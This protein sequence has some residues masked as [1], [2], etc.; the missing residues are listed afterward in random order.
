[1]ILSLPELNISVDKD[2]SVNMSLVSQETP[3]RTI[4]A[5]MMILYNWLAARFCRDNR[6]P[7]IFRGQKEP[8][9]KL[10]LEDTGYVYYVFRQRRKL[11]PLILDVEPR[12]HAGLGLDAY[13]NV[14]SP[15][16]RFFDLVSQRQM[17]N[18][19]FKGLPFYNREELDKI[20][21]Q[22]TSSLKDLNTV[23]R[24]RYNY[25]IN[26]YLEK[27]IGKTLQAIVL[28]VL[29]GRYRIILADFYI[30]VEMKRE[31]DN[32]LSSG[33]QIKV[34]VIRA[35]AWNDILKLEYVNQ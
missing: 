16:R 25:W 19:M 28:D 9:E 6:I 23:R 35:D 14:T 17:L 26:R 24:N 20:R 12:P 33:D 8:S 18:F 34:K 22:V 11:N 15:I 10:P 2:S 32:K 4:V 31:K 3:S 29:K 27:H 21:M 7:T 1:M 13:I 30:A 5:E